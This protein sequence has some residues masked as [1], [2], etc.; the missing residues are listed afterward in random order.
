MAGVSPSEYL[1]GLI[2]GHRA[3]IAEVL[4][5]LENLSSRVESLESGARVVR[6]GHNDS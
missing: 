6:R 2:V 5:R 4:R 3:D 1:R